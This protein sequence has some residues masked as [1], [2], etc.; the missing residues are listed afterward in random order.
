MAHVSGYDQSVKPKSAAELSD[1]LAHE[2]D[3]LPEAVEAARAEL[4]SRDLSTAERE[5]LL[6]RAM[7]NK[8]LEDDDAGAVDPMEIYPHIAR[9]Y[10]ATVIDGAVVL[11]VGFALG[12]LLQAEAMAGLR[13]MLFLVVLF[14]YEPVL[15]SRYC[16]LGQRIMGVRVRD[17]RTGQSISVVRAYLRIVV[18][19]LLGFYSFVSVFFT[20]GRRAVHDMI[21]GSVVIAASADHR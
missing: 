1:V 7:D 11:G 17:W 10:V 15:T 18:K 3:Y 9:R 2:A 13:V 16:T 4:D 14:L 20:Q 6:S 19:I 12:G 21:T 5:M 8:R